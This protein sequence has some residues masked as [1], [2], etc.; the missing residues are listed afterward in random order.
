LKTSVIGFW[1]GRM[2]R[3]L[4]IMQIFSKEGIMIN[5]SQRGMNAEET[6]LN[7]DLISPGIKEAS[8]IVKETT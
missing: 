7:E 8:I 3:R 6:Y 5:K 1:K 2:K 4:R